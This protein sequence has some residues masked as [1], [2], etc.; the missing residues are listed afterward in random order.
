MNKFHKDYFQIHALSSIDTNTLRT[1][2]YYWLVD[3]HNTTHANNMTSQID[4]DWWVSGP[5]NAPADKLN[6]TSPNITACEDLANKFVLHPDDIVEDDYKVYA[7]WSSTIKTIFNIQLT[8]TM[9]ENSIDTE[10]GL[11]ILTLIDQ[12]L[13]IT[14]T[15]NP[16]VKQI[17]FPLGISYGYKPVKEPAI[18]WVSSQGRLKYISPVYG[19]WVGHDLTDCHVAETTFNANKDFYHPLA[20]KEI[21]DLIDSCISVH[22][23]G[24]LQE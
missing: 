18:E 22:T 2:L 4:W 20:L 24:F 11:K 16:E 8:N 19:A 1:T 17:W 14:N 5:Y 21:Q 13:D 23:K 9:A 3:Q 12:C 15:K 7:A 10:N 6:F